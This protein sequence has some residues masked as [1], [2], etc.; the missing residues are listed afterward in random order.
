M[1]TPALHPTPAQRDRGG[2]IPVVAALALPL[3]LSLLGMLFVADVVVWGPRS[4]SSRENRGLAAWPVFSF[5]ALREG[6]YTHE[7]DD[8]V[9]DHFPLRDHF[10]DL[11]AVL[12]D[13]RGL[14][15]RE[16]V[17]DSSALEDFGLPPST[18][19]PDEV[20]P[21]AGTA[22]D[23]PHSTVHA[24]GVDAVDA[25]VA[26][27]AG[28]DADAGANAGP[29][30]DADA[31]PD[32]RRDAGI[33][34]ELAVDDVAGTTPPATRRVLKS[35]IVVADGRGLMYV[36]GDDDGARRFARALNQWALA[37]PDVRIDVLVTP[38]A[39]R[40]YLP[41]VH[42]ELSLDEHEN[43][44]VL[45]TALSPS[46]Q[47]V[48]VEAALAAHVDEPIF[49]R[50]DHHWTGHGAWLAYA[51]WARQAGLLPVDPQTLVERTSAP[52]LGSLYRSTQSRQLARDPEPATYW[53]PSVPYKALRWRTVDGA[54]TPITLLV[55]RERGYNV[56]LGGDDPLIVAQTGRETGRRALL[57]KN[58][59]GNAFAPW[60]VHHFDDVV[61]VDYR[62][63]DGSIIDLVR[64]YRVTDV[65]I[66][67][68]TVTANSAAHAQ[69][70]TEVLRG[71]GRG[72]KIV[73]GLPPAAAPGQ[74][75]TTTTPAT[76]ATTPA[77]TQTGTS[78]NGPAKASSSFSSSGLRPS[79]PPRETER[80]SGER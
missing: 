38:T 47:W 71:R 58:S 69:R 11:A 73:R 26:A 60:L 72:W 80:G 5:A 55:E 17:F 23:E 18:R 65:L 76:P 48:D 41:A 33:H 24:V 67:N 14:Q 15:V 56:F 43:L 3:A 1:A 35:G 44:A 53:L 66:V 30:A 21:D 40:F 50:T 25:M 42:R 51:A 46:L 29:D 19:T 37:L 22:R 68:A 36:V 70:M 7:I 4:T 9:A 13:A 75:N 32:A 8:W 74:G 64:R 59:F 49:F 28:P 79:A 34:A 6:R 31:S 61:I 78:G 12:R 62:Y 39:A 57:V 52:L 45:R 54:P 20:M 27:D 2:A 10:L 77:D 63:Y 16:E